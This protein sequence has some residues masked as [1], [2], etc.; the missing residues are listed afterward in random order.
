MTSKGVVIKRSP[1]L[2]QRLF[3]IHASSIIMDTFLFH[4]HAQ[5]SIAFNYLAISNVKAD[6]LNIVNT[7]IKVL[8]QNYI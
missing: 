3:Q 6:R 2:S 1:A 7:K 4:I 8:Q 5:V